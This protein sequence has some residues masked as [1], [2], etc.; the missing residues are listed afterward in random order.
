MLQYWFP[1]LGKRIFKNYLSVLWKQNG[2]NYERS[3][4]GYKKQVS[5]WL[6]LLGLL[7]P[8]NGVSGLAGLHSFMEHLHAKITLLSLGW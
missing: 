6:V 2:S 5:A 1:L 7:P 8:R 3:I 4:P